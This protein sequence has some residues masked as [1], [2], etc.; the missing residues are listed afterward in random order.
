MLNPQRA[1]RQRKEGYIKKLEEQVREANQMQESY[2]LIQSEN[3][4]LRDYII[5]LQSRLIESQGEEAVPPPPIQ[6]LQMSPSLALYLNH[7]A[8][9]QAAAGAPTANMGG[10]AGVPDLNNM[11]GKRQHDED[12]NNAFLQNVAVQVQGSG[13]FNQ[14]QQQQQA[15]NA[16]PVQAKRAKNINGGMEGVVQEEAPKPT[17]NGNAN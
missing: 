7:D 8:P 6:L 4:Q 2:K 15:G 16:S 13:L 17:T 12:P 3:Y 14:Q 10:V 5:N 1:F 9:P 11:N